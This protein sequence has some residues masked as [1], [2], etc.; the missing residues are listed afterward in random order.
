MNKTI[1]LLL[2]FIFIN[3]FQSKAQN[4]IE[5]FDHYVETKQ[6]EKEK[7][8][9]ELV[10]ETAKYFMNHPYV[11]GTLEINDNEQLVTNLEAFDC[12]TFVETCI[13]LSQTLKYDS[14][15]SYINFQKHL[16]DIRY[17]D[18]AIK[19]YTSRNHYMIDWITNNE[20]QLINITD[21]LGG[22][23]QNK[24]IDFMSTHASLYPALKASLEEQQ[25]IKNIEDTINK[26]QNYSL[27]SVADLEKNKNKLQTGDII[28]FGTTTKGL[29]YSHIGFILKEGNQLKLLH[30][31]SKY[32]KVTID[33]LPLLDYCKNSKTCTGVSILRLKN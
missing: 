25:A 7:N 27:L 21:S 17:K 22:T 8:I 4:T 16:Q 26:S 32:K 28:I 20:N 6:E 31:S 9:N 13:A 10:I 1:T 33:P 18:G 11:G 24:K 12:T 3:I 23:P 19:G 14:L 15:P 30:A 5:L 2:L 29:D